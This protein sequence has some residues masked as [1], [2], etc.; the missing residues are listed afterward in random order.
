MIAIIDYDMGNVGSI[1]NMLRKIG[2][3][4]VITADLAVIDAADKLIL[5]GV[6]AFD[7]GMTNLERAGMLPVL[8]KKVEQGTP[9]L[10][11]CLGME[12]LTRGSEEGRCPG[13]GWIEGRTVRF[14]FPDRADKLNVPHM[15]WNNVQ[16]SST[17]TL[18]RDMPDDA[19]FY[20][21]HS[22]YVAC[23]SEADV[24]GRTHYGTDFASVVEHGNV[25][26]TQFHPEKSHR[27]GMTLLRNFV[28]VA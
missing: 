28:A 15:G 6:G 18:L 25:M 1:A 12:I 26:G 16:P 19:R 22:Y 13:L 27:F 14:A 4:S 20:F 10:G 2:V 11:I 23:D 9:V 8:N 21:V 7:T 24:A 17:S 3:E 5:P